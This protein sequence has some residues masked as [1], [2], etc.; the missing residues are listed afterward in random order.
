MSVKKN[1]LL[2]TR[3]KKKLIFWPN[4]GNVKG[5]GKTYYGDRIGELRRCGDM[6]EK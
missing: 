6:D 2:E 3:F 1:K 5:D 4:S